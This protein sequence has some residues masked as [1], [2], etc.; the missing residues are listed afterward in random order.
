MD[1][2]ELDDAALDRLLDQA[3]HPVA[4]SALERRVLA[5]FH[6]VN[7]RWSFLKLARRIGDAIWPDTPA[8]QPVGALAVALLIG[9]GVAVFAPL[10]IAQQ[11][12]A[13]ANVFAL[14]GSPD[15]DAGQGI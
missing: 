6:R 11:E 8:W 5:D 9:L 15:V 7:A 14:D 3:E 2:N 12:D 1:V 4:S 13:T 10:D